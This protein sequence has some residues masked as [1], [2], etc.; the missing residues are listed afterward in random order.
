MF[1]EKHAIRKYHSKLP[2]ELSRRYG[3]RGPYTEGQVTTTVKELGL[4]DRFVQYAYVMYCHE[5]VLDQYG[6]A[7]EKLQTMLT[8]ERKNS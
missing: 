8:R 1:G 5:E 3:G 4:S 6:L 2:E 7:G